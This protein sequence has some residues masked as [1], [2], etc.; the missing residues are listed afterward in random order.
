MSPQSSLVGYGFLLGRALIATALLASPALHAQTNELA[1]PRIVERSA[2]HGPAQPQSL[3]SVTV[4]LNLHNQ[5]AYDKAVEDLY[6]P[7]SPTFH[8]WFTAADFARYAPTADERQ[9]VRQELESHGLSV[10]STDANGFSLR[11]RG[12]VSSIE[13]AFNT[14]IHEFEREHQTFIANATPAR[15]SGAAAP[16]VHSISGLSTFALRSQARPKIDLHTGKPMAMI[17]LAKVAAAGLGDSFT[18]QCFQPPASI[19]FSTGTPLPVGQFFGN[20]YNQ[21]SL[22]C[23]WTPSQIQAHY[24]LDV[25]YSEG[26][27]GSGQT[28]V[29]V[30][31]P[32][33]PSVAADLAAYSQLTGLP[34]PNASNFKIIYPDGKPSQQTLNFVNDFILE[35][36]LDVEM[37][38]TA[39]PKAKI[40]LLITP[41]IQWQEF[42]FAI[43]Y[44]VDHKLGNVVSVSYDSPEFLWGKFTQQGFE[45]V[46]KTA[47]AAGVAVNF[48]SGDE[49][50]EGTGAP[51]AGGANY[52]ASSAF[53][54]AIGGTS[55]AV[56]NPNGG[57]AEVGWGNDLTFFDFPPFP[58]PNEGTPFPDGFLGGS[59]GGE[60]TLVAQPAWQGGA[61]GRGRMLPD[62]SAIAD[63]DTGFIIASGGQVGIVGGTSASSPL[64]TGIWALANEKAGKSLGQIAPLLSKLPASS[65]NDVGPLSSPTNPA[66][67]IFDTT[68][69]KFYSPESLI[70]PLFTTKHFFSAIFDAG[71]GEFLDISFGTDTSLTITK[72]WDNVTGFGKPNG[73]AFIKNAA[74]F[75]PAAASK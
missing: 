31:G 10:V 42:E 67:V 36:D 21:G 32:T 4:H 71:G 43:Q 65:F 41:T 2:D 29:I 9:T 72:A 68:G 59:G 13:S 55:L 61:H 64:I 46:L 8:H 53:A 48:S 18:N 12:S 63:P 16:L 44:A 60:S 27:N 35:S 37:A 62:I 24:G 22:P 58:L 51:N 20:V 47:A 3:A 25:A 23:G 54:T 56:P 69:S 14:Q 6:T 74:A 57:F 19:T 11:A 50:D 15:L 70:T 26:I 49:G 33:D 7:G 34:A 17:P 39:A 38:H 5:A 45:Q 40:I 1:P 30:G 28:I 75:K 66:G 73:I 52:P